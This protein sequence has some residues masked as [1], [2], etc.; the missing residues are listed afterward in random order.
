[1]NLRAEIL[2]TS[3]RER[4]H[5]ESLRILDQVGVRIHSQK[6][7]KLLQQS[8]AR[9]DWDA[10]IARIP[11]E[12]VEHSL[13]T[14]PQSFTLGARNPAY[15][16][17]LPA[18]SSGYCLDGTGTFAVDFH[19]GE[20]RYGTRKDIENALRVFQ[21]MDLGV[22]AWAPVCASDAPAGSRALHEFIT[23]MKSCSKHGQ[24]ELHRADQVPYLVAALKAILGSEA[25]IRSKKNYSLIYCPVAPLTHEGEM[26][27]AY[28]ELGEFAMP[29]MIMPMPVS[30][31][32]GPAHLFSNLCLANAETLSA[33]VIFQLAHPGRP[34][35]YSNAVGSVDFRNG[36]FLA[37]TPETALHSAAM[38]EMGRFYNL[39][40]TSAGC[41][42]DAKQPG[43]EAVLEK[44][45]T[46]LPSVLAGSDIIV[47]FGEIES[48]QTLILEQIVVDNEIA[49]L[50]KR[51]YEGID[52][53]QEN[54]L[55]ED[56]AQVGPGG[57][58]LKC[59][60]TR[61]AARSVEFYL[62][63]LL[64]RNPYDAWLALGKPNMYTYAR[65][66]VADILAAPIADPLPQ[67]TIA[68]LDE[69]LQKADRELEQSP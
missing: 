17:P 49:H 25:E 56:I 66:F 65:Q 9:I 48:D 29:V 52:T 59:K 51:L 20:K 19:S 47:G 8:G 61:Q 62:P 31:T 67:S 5:R 23:M 15:A 37:G 4:I 60:S 34:L 16:F 43:A 24:H 55:F 63:R 22:M 57:N 64:D 41:S 45:L 33:L 28:L 35:I 46:A 44:F 50:C 39:P 68:E 36:S 7:L 11:A 27:D 30:G 14:A 21:H 69:I 53:S 32:T 58:F 2:S 38:V 40:S 10:K 13:Q 6:A 54:Y 12:L 18:P 26:L 3:D 1:M 42:T